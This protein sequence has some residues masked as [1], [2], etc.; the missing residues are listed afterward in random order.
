M[1]IAVLFI[2]FFGLCILGVPIAFSLALSA[3]VTG[4]IAN[5]PPLVVIQNM[6]AGVDSYTL[7]AVPLF[8]LSGEIM[9]KGEITGRMVAFSRSIVGHI[10]GSLGHVTIFSNMIMAGISGSGTA[11]AAALGTIMIP[12]MK[13]EGYPK[14]MAVAINASAATMGPIIPP[15]IIMIVYGA[16]GGVSIA[17]MFLGGAIPGIIIGVTLM[18]VVYYW[19]R[20]KG[21]PTSPRASLKEIWRTFKGT[22]WALLVPLIIIVGVVGGIFTATESAMI[23]VV[24]ALLVTFFIY[25]SMNLK[26]TYEALRNAL[27]GFANPMLCVAGAGAFGYIMAYLQV[28]SR[29][30]E[31]AGP[32]VGLPI[33]TLLFITVLFLIL[34]TFMDAIPAIVI[35]LP[36]VQKMAVAAH[37]NPVHLGVLVTVVLCFG[38]IT[39]PYGLTLLLSAGIGKASVTKVVRVLVPFYLVMLAVILMIIFVPD[40]VLFLPRLLVPSAVGGP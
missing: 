24:Y 15:S 34:G 26:K 31:L 4:L 7:L 6:F 22:V 1:L 25:K 39:P 18:L 40:I 8:M 23:T 9:E 32:I 13:N 21:F 2:S 17:G 27:V 35:F 19:A 3:L 11:D 16:Y 14:E 30:I 12:A 20:N 36:I 33:P 10:R 5:I 38:L 29:I 37:L 28:P